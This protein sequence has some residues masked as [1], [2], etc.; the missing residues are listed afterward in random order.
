MLFLS[1][2]LSEELQ[3]TYCSPTLGTIT[4]STISSFHPKNFT[5]ITFIVQLHVRLLSGATS[6][7][8]EACCVLSVV[9]VLAHVLLIPVNP[10]RTIPL[11]FLPVYDTG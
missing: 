9:L 6:P 8:V 3:T 10:L 7:G 11:G 5:G 4:Q 2:D 1:P